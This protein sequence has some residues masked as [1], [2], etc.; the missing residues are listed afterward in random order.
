MELYAAFAALLLLGSLMPFDLVPPLREGRAFN[1]A[2][3]IR[4]PDRT[5]FYQ[6]YWVCIY[7]QELAE[8]W[9]VWAV[10]LALAA[11]GVWMLAG[12]PFELASPIVAL[13]ATVWR[14]PRW[15]ARQIEYVGHGVSFALGRKFS[16]EHY[17]E[18][19]AAAIRLWAGYTKLFRDA[20]LKP[21]DAAAGLRRW[22]WLAL[23][24]LAILGP[25]IRRHA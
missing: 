18:P 3:A 13:V 2:L 12:T 19:S 4:M 9:L 6:G 8:W 10:A 5:K 21:A 17:A 16:I 23:F 11:P 7:A 14:R 1:N 24:L 20:G 25:R 22:R 15:C